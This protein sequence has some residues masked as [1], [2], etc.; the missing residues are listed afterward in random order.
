MYFFLSSLRECQG[1][2]ITFFVCCVKTL[3]Y[4]RGAIFFKIMRE[5]FVGTSFLLGLCETFLKKTKFE[6]FAHGIDIGLKVL[7]PSFGCLKHGKY[8]VIQ[9]CF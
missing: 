2:E 6:G 9:K 7:D 3:S 1:K 4:L 5:A 8:K